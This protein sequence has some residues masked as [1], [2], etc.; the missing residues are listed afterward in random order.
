MTQEQKINNM[1]IAARICGFGFDNKGIDLLVS[2]YELI[3]EK[4]G[5]TSMS[6]VTK[7]QMDVKNRDDAKTKSELLDKISEK[8]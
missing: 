1:K 4:E 8:V 6:D 3:S 2:L 5:Q 7:V